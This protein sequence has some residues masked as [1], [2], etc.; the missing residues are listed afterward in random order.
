MAFKVP[1]NIMLDRNKQ[2]RVSSQ[3]FVSG[4]LSVNGMEFEHT[5]QIEGVY[6]EKNNVVIFKMADYRIFGGEAERG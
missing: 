6:S 4:L 5:Y 1:D 3:S 2:M